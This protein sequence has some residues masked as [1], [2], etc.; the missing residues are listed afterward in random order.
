MLT[1]LKR[2]SK[3]EQ[4][5][6]AA[7][8]EVLAASVWLARQRGHN[9]VGTEHVL[10]ALLAR[11][12]GAVAAALESLGVGGAELATRLDGAMA[13]GGET[14]R[15]GPL[16]YTSRVLSALQIAQAAAGDLNASQVD[17]EHLLLGILQEGKG[18]AAQVL[19]GMG[20]TPAAL[21]EILR[22]GAPVTVGPQGSASVSARWRPRTMPPQARRGVAAVTVPRAAAGVGGA[23]EPAGQAP[24]PGAAAP[25]ITIDDGSARSIYEQ[26]ITQFQEAVATGRLHSGERLPT[27]RRLADELDIAPGTVARAYR[28]LERLGILVADG[29]RGTRVAAR[30]GTAVSAE[31]RPEALLE[32]MRKVVIAGFHLGAA[33]AELRGALD[34]AMDGIFEESA[35]EA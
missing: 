30:Q 24:S 20:A 25:R 5:F 1:W 34:A 11:G 18:L 12:D 17:T 13:R 28:E 14:V 9:F 8:R 19:T 33:P 27:V 26:I 7:V 10:Q 4:A 6:G 21:L 23:S 3:G 22:R 32:L 35:D 2:Q 31:A 15:S 16:P 29:A